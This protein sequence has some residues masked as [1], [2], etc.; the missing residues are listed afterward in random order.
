MSL[1]RATAPILLL[2]A[3]LTTGC[4]TASVFLAKRDLPPPEML[5]KPPPPKL[6]PA[7]ATDPEIAEERIRFGVAYRVLEKMFDGLVCY[8][9][10]CK[11]PAPAK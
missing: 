9:V 3:L 10:E 1:S 4:S 2:C 6:A 7:D 5:R 11:P 8:V